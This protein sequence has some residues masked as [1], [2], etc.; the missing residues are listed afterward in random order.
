MHW[1]HARA[2]Y[3]AS[4]TKTL[5]LTLQIDTHTRTYMQN[6]S[7][8]EALVFLY[9]LIPQEGSP[10]TG[11]WPTHSAITPIISALEEHCRYQC[12]TEAIVQVSPEMC[13]VQT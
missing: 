3:R 8:R 13:A 1:A 2:I 4:I 10:G 5:L 12:F 9:K 6:N 7:K 11:L